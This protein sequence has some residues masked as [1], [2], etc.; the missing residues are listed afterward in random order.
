MRNVALTFCISVVLIVCGCS[1]P[2]PTGVWAGN[3]IN[4]VGATRDSFSSVTIIYTGTNT[5]NAVCKI[6]Q[7]GYLYTAF[8]LQNVTLT[9]TTATFDQTQHIIESTD[10]G[11]F[12]FQGNMSLTGTQLTFT[13]VATDLTTH[14]PSDT[15]NFQFTGVLSN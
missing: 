3:Y 13:A 10:L 2:A 9:G 11:P 8:T 6:Y 14:N 15:K 12:L 1:K 7:Y 5:V 4:V